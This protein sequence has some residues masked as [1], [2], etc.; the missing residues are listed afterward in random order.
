MR[1]ENGRTDPYKKKGSFVIKVFMRRFINFNAKGVKEIMF[2][3]KHFYHY[4]LDRQRIQ[5]LDVNL[6][7][8]P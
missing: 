1:R 8:Y 7:G 4:C 2:P 6:D 3:N 5:F